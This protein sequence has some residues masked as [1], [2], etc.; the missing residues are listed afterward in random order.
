MAKVSPIDYKRVSSLPWQTINVEVP[1]ELVVA[2]GNT[3]LARRRCRAAE[4]RLRSTVCDE[5]ASAGR[6]RFRGQVAV[7]LELGG[8]SVSQPDRARRTVKAILD[9]LQG[10]LYADDREVALL[11]VV[12]RPGP[13]RAKISACS[14]GRYT[15]AFD[16]LGGASRDRRGGIGQDA[17]GP[18]PWAWDCDPD[19]DDHRLE[20]A[21]EH[22]AD[23][24]SGALSGDDDELQARMIEFNE[25]EVRELRLARLLSEPFLPPDRPGEQTIQGRLTLD[26]SG[27]PRAGRI[28]VPAPVAG[29]RGSWTAI[30]AQAAADHIARWPWVF[31]ALAGESM[32]LD[33][34]IGRTG[35]NCFDIDNLAHRLIAALR[36]AAPQL[37]RPGSYRGY[38]RHGM[39][40]VVA[41]TLHSE[42]R[43]ERLRSLLNGCSLAVMGLRVDREGRVYRRRP[44][45]DDEV[46]Q[47]IRDLAAEL[48][49]PDEATPSRP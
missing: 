37:G 35:W 28:H 38:R 24:Q 1:E 6:R 41:V 26:H 19:A 34:A 13:L 39:D 5:L 11:D 44:S 2:K 40:D 43:A 16:I 33:I 45:V 23:W 10:P 31:E 27:F 18:N 42:K 17:F 4:A 49:M 12:F 32:M 3:S 46:Y 48:D 30:A 15:D 36:T 9:G 25:R 20:L 8:V 47:G 21:E 29:Q 14:Q 7:H 22:L